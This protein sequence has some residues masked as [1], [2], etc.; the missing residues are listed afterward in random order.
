MGQRGWKPCAHKGGVG[1][2]MGQR[3]W[4]LCAQGQGRVGTGGQS[5]AHPREI[6]PIAT[7]QVAPAIWL[8]HIFLQRHPG[9]E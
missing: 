5:G 4:K 8:L 7:V 6:G 1:D 9:P 3:T 2:R